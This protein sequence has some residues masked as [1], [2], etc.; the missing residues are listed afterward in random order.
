M[1]GEHQTFAGLR[2]VCGDDV[3]EGDLADR[4][5]LVEHVLLYRPSE[6]LHGAHDELRDR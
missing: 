2:I 4:R 6:I 5:L 1:A 3:A